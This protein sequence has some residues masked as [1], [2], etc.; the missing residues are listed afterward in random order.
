M[1]RIYSG[2]TFNTFEINF[3][4]YGIESLLKNVKSGYTISYFSLNDPDINYQLAQSANTITTHTNVPL[5]GQVPSLNG[6]YKKECITKINHLN[7]YNL[8]KKNEG[9]DFERLDTNCIPNYGYF[10]LDMTNVTVGSGVSIG[11]CGL[12]VNY[13]FYDNINNFGVFVKNRFITLLNPNVLAPLSFA[14]NDCL[15]YINENKIAFYINDSKLN[16][17]SC[18]ANVALRTNVRNS[19]VTLLKNYTCCKN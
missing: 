4:E 11:L 13:S 9:F 2:D 14:P 6:L 19:V 5:R 18:N 1:A 10:V 16:C 15:F 8:I 12:N 17:V 3:T 7:K